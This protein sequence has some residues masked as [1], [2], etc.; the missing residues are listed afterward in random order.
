M[1]TIK[2]DSG[3]RRPGKAAQVKCYADWGKGDVALGDPGVFLR[4]VGFALHLQGY[5]HV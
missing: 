3:S 4:K 2:P 1:Q 5:R